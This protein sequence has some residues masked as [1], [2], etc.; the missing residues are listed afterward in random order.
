[1]KYVD[2]YLLPVPKK[3]IKAYRKMAALAGKVWKDH[4][5]LKYFECAGDDMINKWGVLFPKLMKTK[6]SETVIFAFIVFKSKADRDRVNKKV[7]KD[8]RM[9][10]VQGPMPFDIKRMVYG[11]FKAIVEA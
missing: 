6:P 2:G 5:A 3:K 9:N 8:P 10:T 7:M 1:M 11:G 4:G